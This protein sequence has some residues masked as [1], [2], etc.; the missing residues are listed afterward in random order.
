MCILKMIMLSTLKLNCPEVEGLDALSVT[1]RG[2]LW[3]ATR[4]V[5]A[6]ASMFLVLG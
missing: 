1:S 5:V 4:R 6:G 2:L 3:D